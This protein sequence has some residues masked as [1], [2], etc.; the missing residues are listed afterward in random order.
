MVKK[1]VIINPKTYCIVKAKKPIKN[2]FTSIQDKNELTIITEEKNITKNNILA[3]EKNY[4]LIKFDMKLPFSLT[5]FIAKISTALAKAKIPIFVISSF[6]TD[7]ILVKKK[8]INKASK[9][10]KSLGFTIQ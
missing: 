1:V 6:T 8:H 4:K 2:Y 9:K 10:L 7:H 5:G 3:I